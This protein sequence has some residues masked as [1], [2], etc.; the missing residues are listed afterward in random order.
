MPSIVTVNVSLQAAP[1]PPSLQQTGAFVSQGATVQSPG[2]F[3]LLTQL[4]DLTPLLKGA[5]TLTSLTWAATVV[6]AV[7]SA[8]HNL[9][10]GDTLL[11]TV[12]GATP[13]AY[14]GTFLCT[15]TT[16]TQ[17]TYGLAANP[18]S[19][20]VPGAFTLEDVSELVAM[21]TT[22]F[23]Q[24]TQVGVYVLELGPGTPADGVTALTAYITANP[25]ANYTPGATGYFYG[26]LVPRSWASEPTFLAMLANYESPTAKTY[27]WTTATL[28]NYASFTDLMKDG[29]ALIEAPQSSVYASNALT[30]L[31]YNTGDL[32]LSAVPA[33]A[34]S[35]YAPTNVLTAVGG[36][37]TEPTFTVTDTKVVTVTKVT[38]GTGPDGTH[39]FTGTTGTGTKFQ[40]TGTISTNTLT[41]GAITIPGDYTINPTTLGNEPVTASGCTGYV[42]SVAMGVLTVA[43]A[44]GGELTAV[45][46]N[47]VTTTVSPTGGTGCTL[48]VTWLAAPAPGYIS[49]G[50][51]TAH[52][53]SVGD[54]FQ[55]TGCTPLGYNGF[56]EAAAGTQATILVAAKQTNP[57]QET[58][59]GT[60]VGS[61]VASTGVGATEFSL[62]G[63]FQKALSYLPS[64]TN[65]VT[66][67]A[68]SFIFGV[69]P[70]PTVGNSS[71]LTALKNA[72]INYIGTGA[73]GG[74][75]N[76]VL[77]WG[78]TLDGR[79]LTYWYSI[80]WAQINADINI[81]NAVI[82]GSNNPTNP[83]YYNQDGINRLQDVV[84]ATMN[85][86][87]TVGL[88]N[89]RVTQSS[90]A[91]PDF[92]NALN[93]GTFDGQIVVN[94]VPFVPYLTV[95][96]GDYK[97]GRYAG[98]SV[99]YIPNR[100][101]INIV[102]DLNVTDFI[103]G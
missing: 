7:A 60:L 72:N 45:P 37:G 102:F 61:T 56:Y 93:A 83:L 9:P 33:A 70:F 73:E 6:T 47:P 92:V 44:S 21:A 103:V 91:G 90:L 65:K 89:G 75:S 4:S 26:Y 68:F 79:D 22:F 25:N 17:F 27:L 49:A 20:T 63:P 50:T 64:S 31:Q 28:Q 18:G 29:F 54:W 71:L 34:G 53:V 23:G 62:A 78:T 74:I 24:G 80:D 99:Q 69:T 48:N 32:A 19:E 95:N 30:F 57:G 13:A 1:T 97:I 14:N 38:D 55:L 58:M 8:P 12:A 88:A 2:T 15:V 86:A 59:L 100:G 10:I 36:T 16:T 52:G 81:A 35:G 87:V 46:S 67:F 39:T 5:V 40:F 66:P 42:V 51:T 76:T 3:S 84:V 85:S 101:F 82:N 43:L 41:V 11:I 77:F 96:P 98:L 94:A